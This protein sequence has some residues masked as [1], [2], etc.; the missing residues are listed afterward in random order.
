ML[1]T[2]PLRLVNIIQLS[3]KRPPPNSSNKTFFSLD[4]LLENAYLQKNHPEDGLFT[5]IRCKRKTNVLGAHHRACLPKVSQPLPGIEDELF[6]TSIWKSRNQI[7]LN[8][9]SQIL[10]PPALYNRVKVEQLI[11][12]N[13]NQRYNEEWR[14]K[15]SQV[16]DSAQRM[17]EGGCKV[18]TTSKYN[19]YDGADEWFTYKHKH[20]SSLH[21]RIS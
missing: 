5:C 1:T 2:R 11:R 15:E 4:D 9:G 13:I 20:Y 16:W 8:M 10:K 21:D 7:F 6:T 12:M 17:K 18:C 3:K 14:V 19:K